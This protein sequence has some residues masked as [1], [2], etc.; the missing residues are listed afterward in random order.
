MNIDI[1]IPGIPDELENL[2][3]VPSI[4]ELSLPTFDFA[5]QCPGAVAD[6]DDLSACV[7]VDVPQFPTLPLSCP[8]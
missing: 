8:T 2:F 5:M 1:P 4:P 3:D 7:Q 6:G